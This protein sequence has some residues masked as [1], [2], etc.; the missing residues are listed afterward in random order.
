MPRPS[1]TVS[2]DIDPVDLHLHGYGVRG[3]APDRLVYTHALPRLLEAFA[4]HGVRA[5]LF[6]V[7]R[8]ADAQRDA[9]RAA[10][11]AGHEV[12]SHSLTHP[13]GLARLGD[14]ALAREVGESK[15]A[16]EAATATPVTGFRAPQFDM[17][18]RAL[19]ALA[20]AG[21]AYDASGCPSQIVID[22]RIAMLLLG[23]D[24]I[25]PL[26]L[27]WLPFTWRRRPYV[28]RTRGRAIHEFP[29][30]VTPLERKP[31][32][33]SLRRR[34]TD[35]KFRRVLGGYVWRREPIS[36]LMHAADVLGLAED[37]VDRRMGRWSGMRRPLAAKLDLLDRTLREIAQRF[38]CV[39]YRDRLPA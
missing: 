28:H 23:P 27:R 7:A 24:R 17:D 12:A 36:Y 26:R 16:L 39:P 34:L 1:A 9:L 20:D 35:G 4:R 8:D 2:V 30:S 13:I 14:A 33:H 22:T 19:A 32:H 6:V 29:L 15:R 37:G 18:G 3:L 11:A 21:Y 10:L 5:T 38:D 25:A 31:L